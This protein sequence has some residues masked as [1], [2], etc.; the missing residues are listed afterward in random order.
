M[1]MPCAVMCSIIRAFMAGY[2][3]M[4]PADDAIDRGH[5]GTAFQLANVSASRDGRAWS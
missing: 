5:E 2:F 4:R 1:G 3:L